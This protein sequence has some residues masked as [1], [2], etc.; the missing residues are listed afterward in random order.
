[1]RGMLLA[2]SI[3]HTK[4]KAKG[5]V[6]KNAATPAR[7]LDANRPYVYPVALRI[8]HDRSRGIESHRLIVEKTGIKFRTAMDLQIGAGVG[9][10]GET[11]GV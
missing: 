11:D 8:F 2:Q 4:A 6:I 10:D 5:V 3:H 7:T 9:Q 1:M